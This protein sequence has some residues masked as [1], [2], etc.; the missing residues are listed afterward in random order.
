LEF[1]KEEE[2]SDERG[3]YLKENFNGNIDNLQLNK[4]KERIK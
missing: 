4:M 2:V 3:I 1:D